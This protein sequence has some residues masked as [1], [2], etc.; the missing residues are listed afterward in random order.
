MLEGIAIACWACE[1]DVAYFFIR[2]E[3]HH[4]AKVMEQV[5]LKNNPFAARLCEIFTSFQP[6]D[7]QYGDLFFDEYVDLYSCMSPTASREVKMQTAFRLYDFDGNGYLS[8]EDIIELIKLLSKRRTG[9][10]LLDDTEVTDI[11]ERVMRDCDIDGNNR[12][13]YS[14]FGKVLGRMPDFAAKF[15]INIH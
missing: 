1:I 5:E 3:Y 15:R 13:S 11:C 4:Q 6:G 2:G 14:E 10:S 8:P 12:L 9:T 7:R